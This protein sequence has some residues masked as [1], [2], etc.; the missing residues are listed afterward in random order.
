MTAALIYHDITSP[1]AP[2]EVGFPGSL[3]ARY[4]LDLDR[5]ERHLDAIQR[6]GID[7]GLVAPGR[8]RPG[9]ALTFDDGGKSAL[10]AAEALERRGW[11]GHFFITTARLGTPGFVDPEDVLELVRGGHSVG[12]HSHSHPTFMG[13]LSPAEIADEWER[14]RAIL[15]EL[16]GSPPATASVPGGFLSRSVVEEAERAG[17][18][19][20]FTSE[21]V[22]RTRREGGLLVLGRYTIW[23]STEPRQAAAYVRG[24]LPVRARLWL[25]WNAKG[26]AKRLSPSVYQR[27]RRIR[28]R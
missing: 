22:T 27:L 8:A 17:Y 3:A 5:F 16:L 21:P 20:L 15:A 28:A 14:S 24:S 4:K 1:E 9:A 12:S 26:I 7:V 11:R 6:A 18:E 19:L 10:V 13:R 2:D 23:A 25:E